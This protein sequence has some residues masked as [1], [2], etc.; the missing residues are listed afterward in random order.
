M[1]IPSSLRT[2]SWEESLFKPFS[3]D[4]TGVRENL[5]AYFPTILN[6]S[7]A[8]I[9]LRNQGRE[10]VSPLREASKY[11]FSE[12][13]E[14]EVEAEVKPNFQE[15]E[16]LR[17]CLRSIWEVIRKYDFLRSQNDAHILKSEVENVLSSNSTTLEP[18]VKVRPPYILASQD[19][20]SL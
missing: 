4:F 19:L 16:A 7:F 5:C 11:R 3:F 14:S 12:K 18:S 2:P 1:L 9:G 13:S 17:R 15:V 8:S 10:V 6:L 20:N